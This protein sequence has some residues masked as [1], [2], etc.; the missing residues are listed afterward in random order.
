M[1][2]DDRF[3]VLGPVGS[4][5]MCHV[6]RARDRRHGE[7]VAL[8]TLQHLD[9]STLYRLK[10]EFRTLSRYEHPNLVQYLEMGRDG[11]GLYVAMEF[12]EGV[13]FLTWTR[14]VDGGHG[15]AET[16]VRTT[17]GRTADSDES[18]A[19]PWPARPLVG[20]RLPDL[21]KLR[22]AVGQLAEGVHA[23]HLSGRLHRDLKP[24]NVLVT[25][26]GRL[27]VL[28][29]GLV[30]EIDQDYTEG[31][32]IEGLAGSA[33]YMSPEQAVGS[34]LSPASDWYSV[35][36][37]LY[38]ALT[39]V[40]PIQGS[41]Y[42]M[43]MGKQAHEATP[44]AIL[45]PGVP[46]DL[47]ALCV[48]LLRRDPAARLS[49]D[50]ILAALRSR[51]APA[52]RARAEA[53]EPRMRFR[54]RQLQDLVRTVQGAKAPRTS[55]F[56]VR[57][58]DGS[59]RTRFLR[60]A[61]KL[62][63]R[64]EG[65][66]SV[67]A[68]CS[69][70][71]SVPYQVLDDLMDNVSRILRRRGASALDDV[72]ETE[73]RAL[74][75]MFPVLSRVD[76]LDLGRDVRAPRPEDLRRAPYGLRQLVRGLTA[77][78]LL[79]LVVDDAQDGDRASAEMLAWVLASETRLRLVV[80]I[81]MRDGPCEF[82]EI[83][84]N[85][86]AGQGCVVRVADL[87]PLT[88]E[89]AA[90]VAAEALRSDG[91]DPRVA[92][93]VRAA[94]GL[95]KRLVSA[96]MR[97][98][99][100]PEAE[101]VLDEVTVGQIQQI[102]PH[103]RQLLELLALTPR[104][105]AVELL[106]AAG[107]LGAESF[108]AITSLRALRLIRE[109]T[110]GETLAIYGEALRAWIDRYLPAADRVARHASLAVTLEDAGAPEDEELVQHWAR[111]GQPERAAVVAWR[112]AQR[113]LEAQDDLA[114]LPLIEA[115]LEFGR[116][117][118]RE[119]R[120]VA[121]TLA[122]AHGRLGHAGAAA[123]A[124]EVALAQSPSAERSREIRVARAEQLLLTGALDEAFAAL[125]A[126]IK[127]AGGT[128]LGPRRQGI[129]ARLIRGRSDTPFSPVDHVALD[130]NHVSRVEATRV[131][132]VVGSWIDRKRAE[133]NREEHRREA[134]ELGHV[135]TMVRAEIRQ[136]VHLAESQMDPGEPIAR[137]E[138]LALQTRGPEGRAWVEAGRARIDLL[139]GEWAS[140]GQRAAGAADV[141]LR[142]GEATT[143]EL[144]ELTLIVAAGRWWGADVFALPELLGPPR[145]Q[146]DARSP[147]IVAHGWGQVGHLAP[148]WTE[149]IDLEPTIALQRRVTGVPRAWATVAWMRLAMAS[150]D[151]AGA[152]ALAQAEWGEVERVDALKDPLLRIHLWAARAAAARGAGDKAQI[153][154]ACQ[155]L[156]RE[157]A[158]WA[159]GWGRRI[160][161]GE[162]SGEPPLVAAA[163]A[164]SALA[165]ALVG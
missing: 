98:G 117:T 28:D 32:L 12:V 13:D 134:A 139:H 10:Q 4:G 76:D 61:V 75:A 40:W 126:V 7:I 58:P 109:D 92:A 54:D 66:L 108:P 165:R 124:L 84:A 72:D 46:S 44:P 52:P 3:E 104:G 21:L 127:E 81:A 89:Q 56:V 2:G 36:V 15:R 38:E 143:I 34:P 55:V 112:A 73:V 39:G 82:A 30:A 105:L 65:A 146:A 119:R 145:G 43:L 18:A 103:W 83:V 5:A 140:A 68:R 120:S 49:G 144:L 60:E 19:P 24:S 80:L 111:G 164:G 71:E 90:V 125:D 51:R 67:K 99:L 106:V 48:A 86:A 161:T 141:L 62:V 149:Q 93:L 29:F 148:L 129:F 50:D 154:A 6:H 128:G 136:A 162:P 100:G 9:A 95:P 35:G 23:L 47:D 137:A 87:E 70:I 150:G 155:V 101:A 122:H 25:A 130:P 16:L 33:A 118:S 138:Q 153:A 8:K 107:G 42:P 163:E 22:S 147:V 41:L 91:A 157:S 59:G 26:A 20:G 94:D 159:R 64:A 113:A 11:Q 131:A 79:L 63:R 114:A 37:M 160:E 77:R 96:A 133:P 31:T 123:R 158:P 142:R 116:W 27:V 74:A 121:T 14:G 152:L 85:E 151:P 53:R 135:P 156:A 1:N 97:D 88:D 45:V 69:A 115:A 17:Q 78:H 102:P 110:S 57:G 132:W